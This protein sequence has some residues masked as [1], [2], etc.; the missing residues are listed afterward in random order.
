MNGPVRGASPHAHDPSGVSM[1]MLQVCLALVPVTAWAF[2]L[3][4]WPAVF[5]WTLCISAAIASE[6]LSLWLMQ[7]PYSRLLDGSGLLTGWLLA[8]T[9]P[10]WCPW[11]VA[12]GGA[13]FAIIIG[14][15]IYGGIGQNIFNPALL[16]RI[17]LLISFP[18]PLTTWVA[19]QLYPGF[20]ESLGIVFANA[21]L[22][23]LGVDGVTGATWLGDSKAFVRAGGD[24]QEYM[25][26]SF[27][28]TDA[29]FGYSR[30]SMGEVSA[31]LALLG[32][33]YLMYRRIISWH[34]PLSLLGTVALLAVIGH[35]AN[36]AAFA[37]LQFHLLSGGLILGAFFY[38]TDYVTTPSSR[39]GQI[40]FGIGSGIL[41]YSIRSWGGFPEAVAFGILM[42]NALTPLI[43]RVTRPRVYGRNRQG[44][45][46]K[47]VS[48]QRRVN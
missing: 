4:G 29:F 41:I 1:I 32:G 16:A 44:N 47:H 7:Q 40:L 20:M 21:P 37:P 15:Q 2:Y 43:D 11:W 42:M 26:S 30:G 35:Q 9:L 27:S 46:I 14:K 13:A 48:A 18:V 31:L 17:A 34:I 10:P 25:A 36:A 19:P 5:V 8:L 6:A 38:A 45:A 23:E 12:V 33:A 3:F 24:M 22:S 28:L 39:S